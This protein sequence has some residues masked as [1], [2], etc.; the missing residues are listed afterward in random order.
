MPGKN[1][2][3][4]YNEALLLE[5]QHYGPVTALKLVANHIYVGYGPVLKVFHLD[6]ITGDVTLQRSQRAFLRNKI[7]SIGFCKKLQRIVLAGGRSFAVLDLENSTIHEKAI[8]EWIVAC[9]FL[10]ASHVLLLTSHNEVLKIDVSDLVSFKF[11]LEEKI[12]CNE[13]SILYSGSIQIANSGKV[14]VA[15]GTV[16]S[17]IMIWD[18]STRKISHVLTDHE[19]SIFGVK[20]SEDGKYV[21]SCSDDRSVKLYDL[22]KSQLLASGWGHGS[23]IW[24]LLFVSTSDEVKIF[25][26]GEDCTA[27]LWSY[28]KDTNTLEQTQIWDHCHLGKHIWSGDVAAE[29][30][31]AVTGGADGKVRVHDISSSDK[32]V[33]VYTPQ[34]IPG[35]KGKEYVAQFSELSQCNVLVVLTSMGNVFTLQK[36]LNVW[37][38][39]EIPHADKVALKGAMLRGFAAANSAAV[40]TRL[41]GIVALSFDVAGSLKQLDWI[42]EGAESNK[43]INVLVAENRENNEYY[44]L[45]DCPNP[46]VPFE[47]IRLA[48]TPEGLTV[49]DSCKLVKPD[50][51]VFTPTSV[52]FDGR[53]S[54][55]LVGSRH[56]NF[57]IYSLASPH[58][59]LPHLIRKV[60]PGDTITS[61]S[62]VQ[63]LPDKLVALLTIRDGV[64]LYM[65]LTNING[66][67][68]EEIILQNKLS[69]GTLEGGFVRNNELYVY[70]FRS[71]AFSLWNETKQIEVN[72]HVC[73]GAHRQWEFNQREST[74]NFSFVYASKSG[75]ISRSFLSRFENPQDGLLVG[76]THGR[77]VRSVAI[78][79]AQEHNGARLMV[80][81]SE[82]ATVRMGTL[83]SSGNITYLWTLNNHISGLQT[84]AFANEQ[85]I[86]SSAA[87]EEL[88]V[89]KI[90]RVSDST[91]TMVEHSRLATSEE[92]SD[93]RIMDFSTIETDGGFWVAAVYSNS[94]IKVF[95]YNTDQRLFTLVVDD[96]YS[97]FCILNANFLTYLE[98]TYLMV[99][100][101]DGFVTIWDVTSNLKERKS[102]KLDNLV[103]LQQ[104][105]QSGVKA[106][107]I[108]PGTAEWT[109]ITGGD[110]N[111]LI[112]SKLTAT[113]DS[114]S[115]Q[116]ASF[117]EDAA[118]ATITGISNVGSTQVLVTSVDQI[119]RLWDFST[120]VLTLQSAN[121]TTVA[122]TGCCDTTEFD[123]HYYG[124]VG[125]AGLG[126]WSINC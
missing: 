90:H 70:G 101:T 118:S 91:V 26:T 57:A 80:S 86:V 54:W 55:L 102:S 104:L 99:G 124:L 115:L 85:Y 13:K 88:L 79:P 52:H 3:S 43:V 29:I 40:F 68:R 58:N 82:D 45:L 95:F 42:K 69:R 48:S 56:A 121:Y 87:N 22:E 100:T 8:N 117:M 46:N 61:I 47:L 21:I 28:A 74:L 10:D 32:E 81:A 64:Y 72:H 12:H 122:D 103:V 51:K 112:L 19:G 7:H 31:M 39:V 106:L 71:S 27:R 60:C 50:P 1:T 62:T 35:L 110:D 38:Q 33:S 116:V 36:D 59:R 37:T 49:V 30:G 94:Q 73:G 84:I 96:R 17:G 4:S 126:F 23:R 107:S 92:N 78:S 75:L 15:A 77:E 113:D 93:L 53:N 89:W 11:C 125:G 25:S 67:F 98:K 105:H 41:G 2:V 44:A 108:V 123:G 63:S 9:E 111:A 6:P 114:L 34:D 66:E 76:G 5:I 109:I 65:S 83:D 20:V 24:S 120:G 97:T 18:L 16:M 14:Y 119:V